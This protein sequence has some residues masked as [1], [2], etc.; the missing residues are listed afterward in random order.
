MKLGRLPLSVRHDPKKIKDVENQSNF[1]HFLGELMFIS[2]FNIIHK[3]QLL[4]KVFIARFMEQ[5]NKLQVM[6]DMS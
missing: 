1:K 6:L 5:V 4:I 2:L 3:T